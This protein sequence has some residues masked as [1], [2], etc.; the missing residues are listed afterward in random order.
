MGPYTVIRTTGLI[1]ASDTFIEF[2]PEMYTPH[3]GGSLI[4]GNLSWSTVI[5][6]GAVSDGLAI[7][8]TNNCRYYGM[9]P[10]DGFGDAVT[11]VPAAV[12]V[13]VMN[14]EALQ[15]TSGIV[16]AGRSTSQ[17]KLAGDTRTWADLAEQFISFQR[18]RLC[19]AAKLAMRGVQIDAVPLNMNELSNFCT[20]RGQNVPGGAPIT[21]NGTGDSFVSSGQ[22]SGFSPIV[23]YNPNGITLQ[24]LVS[25]EWRVRFDP[26]NVAAGTHT[27]HPASSTNLWERVVSSVSALGNG[28][29]DI[30]D[31]VAIAG[32]AADVIM[33]G[34]AKA[35]ML[36]D[37]YR[38][39]LALAAA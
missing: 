21:W 29:V 34:A 20:L 22:P 28:V 38:P 36:G 17:Y 23:V 4:E 33:N 27:M 18:P 7:N 10:F 24:Y 39:A 3:G 25:I 32:Q 35:K 12:S 26:A 19:A 30:A 16:Y 2:C 37:L 15:T 13:Q 31:K 5:A 11:L 8:A 6:R 14:P 9:A 1:A